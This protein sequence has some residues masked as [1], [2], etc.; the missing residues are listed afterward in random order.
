MSTFIISPLNS[1]EYKKRD[2]ALPNYNNTLQSEIEGKT[3]EAYCQ[4]FLSADNVRTQ[5]K[6]DYQT[7]TATLIDEAGTETSLT[8]TEVSTYTDF[9]FWE[10]V[11]TGQ[12]TGYY[13]IKIQG[14]DPAFDTVNY[15]SEPIE[16]VEPYIAHNGANIIQDHLKIRHY[17]R[18]NN[19]DLDYSTGIEHILWIPAELFEAVSG[20]EAEIYNNLGNETKLQET[21][22]RIFTLKTDPIPRYLFLK[23]NEGASQDFFEVNTIEYVTNDKG[24][25]EYSNDYTLVS[26][27]AN[28]TDRFVVG[29]NSD[30]QGF[31]C[32]DIETGEIMLLEELN[33]FGTFQLQVPAG[34]AIEWIKL[35]K[36]TGTQA[37]ID[38][39]WSPSGTDILDGAVLTDSRANEY[40]RLTRIVGEASAGTI[41]GEVSGVGA[42]VNI[43]IQLVKFKEIT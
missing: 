24:E 16:I 38:M 13:Y 21:N 39:G 29:L 31:V 12:S 30:D 9:S 14:T 15:Q 41:Y 19:F 43:Y 20:G 26:F 7:V 40:S 37:T 22:Q 1:I 2:N 36:Q 42:T 18:E 3:N 6:T 33:A 5:I 35:F 28:L 8:V 34:Y 27:S 17:N 32:P 11:F 25:P 23:I 4:K 10:F